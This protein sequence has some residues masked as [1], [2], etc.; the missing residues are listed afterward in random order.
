MQEARKK[1]AVVGFLVPDPGERQRKWGEKKEINKKSLVR[2]SIK[3]PVGQYIR[4]RDEITLGQFLS[5][6][7]KSHLCYPTVF[8]LRDLVPRG[9]PLLDLYSVQRKHTVGYHHP[10]LEEIALF[11]RNRGLDY[12][13]LTPTDQDVSIPVWEITVG[14][15]TDEKINEIWNKV[16]KCR[17]EDSEIFPSNTI[18]IDV[19]EIKIRKSDKD[20]IL[21]SVGSSDPVTTGNKLSPGDK[22]YQWPAKILLGN[23]LRYM[24]VVSWPAELIKEGSETYRIW[25]HKPQDLLIDFLAHLPVGVGVGIKNDTSQLN[26]HFSEFNPAHPLRMAK[27]LDLTT[28]AALVGWRLQATNMAALSLGVLGG[29]MDKVSS[30]ADGKWCLPWKDLP[31]EFQI[32]AVGDVKFGHMCFVVL[33]SVALLDFFPDPEAVMFITDLTLA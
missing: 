32:Y 4:L 15:S 21:S 1:P 28:L 16:E 26:R 9:V 11:Q 23:G 14:V 6:N 18:S 22:W 3:N 17:L 33:S 30:R 10:P 12:S 31:K 7:K 19:E 27:W 8:N 2:N 25:P 29:L 13:S 5:N 24:V 20:L